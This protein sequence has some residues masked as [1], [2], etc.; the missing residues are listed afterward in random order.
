MISSRDY[1]LNGIPLEKQV[2]HFLAQKMDL[3]NLV[4]HNDFSPKFYPN[5][6]HNVV[7]IVV[8]D[9]LLIEVTNPK[10][11]TW[12][13]DD[14]MSNKIDYLHRKDPF[15]K[16]IWVMLI[17]FANFSELITRKLAENNI[18][19]VVLNIHADNY[20]HCRVVKQLFKTKLY[21]L[22]K[23]IFKSKFAPK[24]LGNNLLDKYVVTVNT[25][26]TS[27]VDNNNNLHQH[28]NIDSS[29]YFDI[30]DAINRAKRLGLFH[31]YNG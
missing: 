25:V 18:I 11:S 23:R 20:S 14:I 3:G 19:L 2:V 29:N 9:K 13:D 22:V 27:K 12:M 1:H 4:D 21:H 8:S 30:Q 17:S 5:D 28:S 26:N 16:L 7:D 6:N 10:E 15:H 24:F 31:D